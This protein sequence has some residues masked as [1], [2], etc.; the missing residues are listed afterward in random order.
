M[1]PEKETNH[2]VYIAMSTRGQRPEAEK[3]FGA[4]YD[5][6]I[7]WVIA[8]QA[9]VPMTPKPEP[10]VYKASSQVDRT[11]MRGLPHRSMAAPG[12]VSQ[13]AAAEKSEKLLQQLHDFGHY[14]K[15]SAGRSLEERQLA[16]NLRRARKAKES[17]PEQEAEVQALRQAEQGS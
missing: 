16:K 7:A 17:S 9:C 5:G 2:K 4:D 8:N 12:A 6:D 1:Q 13:L 14:P 3:I 15:E 10:R 11:D